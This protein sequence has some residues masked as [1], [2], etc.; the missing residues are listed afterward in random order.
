MKNALES[1]GNRED[2]MEEKIHKLKD[3]NLEMIHVEEEVEL[4]FVFCFVF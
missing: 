3:R 4:S 1:T 2:H